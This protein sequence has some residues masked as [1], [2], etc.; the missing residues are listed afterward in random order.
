MMNITYRD[1]PYHVSRRVPFFELLEPSV[2]R[3]VNSSTTRATGPGWFARAVS[4]IRHSLAVRRT[5]AE[6][7]RLDDRTLRDIGLHRTDIDAAAAAAVGKRF[8]TRYTL[9]A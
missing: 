1:Y 7:S 3:P 9:A 4:R 6:L 5:V 2:S 8:S